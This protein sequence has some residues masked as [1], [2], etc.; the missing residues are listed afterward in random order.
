MKKL[1][2]LILALALIASLGVTAWAA[3]T[4][5]PTGGSMP[6]DRAL[7]A[8]VLWVMAGQPVVNFAPG[9][10]DL[11]T[12]A[13][14]MNAVR[15]AASEGII[16]GYDA[17]TFGPTD[18]VTREQ[19]SVMLYRYAQKNGLGFTGAWYFP[20][21]AADAGDVSDWA[22]EAMHW[23]VMSGEPEASGEL[24]L[25][26]AVVTRKDLGKM[27]AS[28]ITGAG[29]DVVAFRTVALGTTP[30]TVR[31][32][33]A[34]IAGELTEEGQVAC[35]HSGIS[36]LEL[37][38]Y[39]LSKTGEDYAAAEAAAAGAA[40]EASEENG[41]PTFQF[42]SADR[43]TLT[44]LVDAGADYLK[45]VFRN[46]EENSNFEA[47][48]TLNTLEKA[49]GT[50][51]I[52]MPGNS[53]E[54]FY[55]D[56]SRLQEQFT[57]AGY[58]VKLQYT[59]VA[60]GDQNEDIL[61]MLAQGVDLLCICAVD[62]DGLSPAM[63][64]AKA[65][66]VPVVAYDR[67]ING[68]DAV[69]AYVSYDNYAV[70]ALQGAYVRDALDLDNAAGPF[71]I[72]FVAGSPVDNNAPYVFNG[73]YDV[74]KP[75]I[76]AGKL[77]VPSG[78][79]TFEQA[80]VMQWESA[81]S[82]SRFERILAAYYADGT[83][84]DAVVCNS[85]SLAQGVGAALAAGY[86]VG[87]RPVITGQD[88][89]TDNLR[90]IADGKQ[91][92]TVYKDLADEAAVAF[93]V[94]EAVLEG[95][96]LDAALADTLP[97]KAVYDAE[98]YHNGVMAVPSYLLTP[99]TITA[100]NVAQYRG[101]A[102]D[103]TE[104][105]LG[106]WMSAEKDGQPVLTNEKGVF[107]FVSD[108]KAYSSISKY[109][110]SARRAL[111]KDLAEMDV[112]IDGS[113]VTLTDRSG[114]DH[115]TVFEFVITAISDTE[116]TA[117]RKL[118]R[119]E[120]GVVTRTSEAFYRYVKVSADYS[121]AI[122]GTWEGRCTSAGS[123]FDDGKEHRWSYNADG[124]YVYLIKDGDAW[125]PSD[126]TLNEYFVA[127]NLLCTRWVDNGVENREWW[128]ITID[129]GAMHWTALRQNDDGTTFTA[130]FEMTKVA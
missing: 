82:R 11:N 86:T 76:D 24:L 20:L 78:E 79:T 115:A 63:T 32:P 15:W 22:D 7:A 122:V 19:F 95:K 81:L 31:I 69:S 14:Y 18:P 29:A 49:A 60:G 98:S 97:A 103:L 74:L 28:F 39:Q 9:F 88:A 61:A 84:L 8:T 64:E 127:G 25:P 89:A 75:Y 101:D 59:D 124:S 38:V 130:T 109:G 6:A 53:M 80:A 43:K 99:S 107:A 44:V 16:K 77:I 118:I 85:D 13:R 51:G 125:V 47:H 1:I 87:N 52:L 21:T 102:A 111:W 46:L 119:L 55:I 110:Q 56:G 106:T 42:H 71:R 90:A 96:T 73:A 92:M 68:T 105:I 62:C 117:N 66:G 104:M 121:A 26:K 23:V 91:S 67:L 3:E 65:K 35:W 5:E 114:E 33:E 113:K 36:D 30:Y 58:E 50:V 41:I 54:R 48:S 12:E 72:E 112:V 93:A 40:A 120:D 10:E 123:V 129:G 100:E 57:A 4:A 94:C 34:F 37:D 70:G 128:E 17:K 27:I 116:F 83:Q 108:T 45:L 2:A 126:N